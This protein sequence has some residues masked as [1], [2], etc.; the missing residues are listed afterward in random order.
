MVADG[1]RYNEWCCFDYGNAETNNQDNGPATMETI[2]FG[3]STQW[4]RGSGT[5]PWVMA[6]LE[7]GV[8]AGQSFDPPPTN[9]SIDVDYVT[10]MLKGNSGNYFSLKAGDAQSGPLT[11][12][13]AGPRPDGY[14]PQ[15]KEGAIVLGVGGDN[16]HTGIG[17]FF[18]GCITSGVSSD[19][20]DDAVQENIVAAGYGH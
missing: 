14:S 6:D 2:Y 13:Y 20:V 7:D 10:A 15:K 8:F 1:R 11:T 12:K 17:T 4:G 16:S 18:E 3:S 9:T 19:A 5:G